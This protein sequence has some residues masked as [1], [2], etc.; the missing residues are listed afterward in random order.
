MFA[1]EEQERDPD[2][3]Q[4][5]RSAAIP[6]FTGRPST[7]SRAHRERADDHQ[8]HAGHDDQVRRRRDRPAGERA[9][10]APR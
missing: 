7:S 8:H 1:K 6:A 3:D 5:E 10:G 4:G 2:A 9:H